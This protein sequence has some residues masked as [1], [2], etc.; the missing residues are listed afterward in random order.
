MLPARPAASDYQDRVR[1]LSHVFSFSPPKGLNELSLRAAGRVQACDPGSR[2]GEYPDVTDIGCRCRSSCA[3][4]PP[5]RRRAA[6]LG[7]RR[8]WRRPTIDLPCQRPDK[9][10]VRHAAIGR[11]YSHDLTI[12]N[13]LPTMI[14]FC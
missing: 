14:Y 9:T 7:R 2:P 4:A 13:T 3:A 10:D 6:P 5:C 12:G 8:P 11:Q 1:D